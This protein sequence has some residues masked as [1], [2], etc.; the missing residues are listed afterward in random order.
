MICEICGHETIDIHCK[1]RCMNCGAMMD[2]SDY[3]PKE[4]PDDGV[5][6]S[7]LGNHLRRIENGKDQRHAEGAKDPPGE[8][9]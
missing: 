7:T 5:S 6:A 8:E 2:C 1:V 9:G 4:K 3:V